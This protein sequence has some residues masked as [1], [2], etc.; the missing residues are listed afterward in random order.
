MELLKQKLFTF[1]ENIRIAFEQLSESTDN[2]ECY[3]NGGNNV[4]NIKLTL[5]LH[6]RPYDSKNKIQA[7]EQ[8]INAVLQQISLIY[9]SNMDE[10]DGAKGYNPNLIELTQEKLESQLNLNKILDIESDDNK[11]KLKKL[12]DDFC[13]KMALNKQFIYLDSNN[14][15]NNK[16]N[17]EINNEI[18]KSLK[19]L[20]KYN[21]DRENNLF[22][23][24]LQNL[25]IA[26]KKQDKKKEEE[27]KKEE[28]KQYLQELVKDLTKILEEKNKYCKETINY[29]AEVE[30]ILLPNSSKTFAEKENDKKRHKRELSSSIG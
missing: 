15:I 25:A 19:E 29:T 9:L 5:N 30:K 8:S 22:K 18:N 27:R 1:Y 28:K 16:I 21:N 6:L 23:V 10:N 13:A 11:Q 26:I 4:N 3:I 12:L 24:A 14:K 7:L 17:N 20:E 2:E